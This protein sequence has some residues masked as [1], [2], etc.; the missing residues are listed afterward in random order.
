MQYFKRG[1]NSL[2]SKVKTLCFNL[3]ENLLNFLLLKIKYY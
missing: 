3:I 2:E 1:K